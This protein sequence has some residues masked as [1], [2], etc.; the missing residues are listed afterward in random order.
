MAEN[1]GKQITDLKE[2]SA[3]NANDYFVVS[4]AGNTELTKVSASVVSNA[5]SSV[6]TDGVYSELVYATSQGKNAI[7][8]AL[9]SKGVA[10]TASETLIQMAD[11]VNNLNVDT[12][13]EYW[14]GKLLTAVTQESGNTSRWLKYLPVKKAWLV[15]YGTYLYYV[16]DG[17]EFTGLADMVSKASF[18][19]NTA[20]NPTYQNGILG[21]SP[22]NDYVI[23]KESQYVVRKYQTTSTAFVQGAQFTV[24]ENR[25]PA[26]FAIDN[27]GKYSVFHLGSGGQ[28]YFLDWSAEEPAAVKLEGFPGG[29][30]YMYGGSNIYLFDEVMYFVYQTSSGAGE[31]YAR[32]YS[33]SVD[34]ESGFSYEQIW[35]QKMDDSRF[36][37]SNSWTLKLA[38]DAQTLFVLSRDADGYDRLGLLFKYPLFVASA[39]TPLQSQQFDIITF[40]Q[41]ESYVYATATN[42]EHYWVQPTEFY[43]T[44]NE[45]GKFELH[46]AVLQEQFFEYDTTANTIQM[47]NA[48]TAGGVVCPT[49]YMSDYANTSIK[50]GANSVLRL[51][52]SGDNY[53]N[54]TYMLTYSTDNKILCTKR[55]VNGNKELYMIDALR[56]SPSD[57][58][59]GWL[60]VTTQITPAVPDE[61]DPGAGDASETVYQWT[62]TNADVA[63]V[64]TKSIPTSSSTGV[65][66]YTT[67]DC[68]TQAMHQD[69]PIS[70]YY[71]TVGSAPLTQHI[72]QWKTTPQTYGDTANRV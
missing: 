43:V 14:T 66:A 7:A 10:T 45:A 49:W 27:T 33:W 51:A 52:S 11:K 61:E 57:V 35:S 16:P 6:L 36:N 41:N 60:D 58:A 44:K 13:A 55:T 32:K 65:T 62:L 54:F 63:T 4:Q 68:T 72:Y 69:L 37:G 59:D 22:N 17:T 30:S 25:S 8:T 29:G 26:I 34:A 15:W 23:I 39:E 9:T 31:V 1:E 5:V 64:Y 53:Q 3:L 24:P 2:T 67:A 38:D 46:N 70:L 47:V 50:S 28:V 40:E 18:S 12:G 42:Y 20:V 21:F 48:R 19:F 71:M 56:V